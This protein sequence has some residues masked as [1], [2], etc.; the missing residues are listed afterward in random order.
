MIR[1]WFAFA[2]KGLLMACAL[3]FI[4]ISLLMAG[5]SMAASTIFPCFGLRNLYGRPAAPAVDEFGFENALEA[6]ADLIGAHA[7]RKR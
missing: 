1:R 7:G 4:A 3:A 6:Y 2:L 5:V